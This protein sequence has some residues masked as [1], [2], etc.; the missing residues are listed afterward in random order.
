MNRKI[1]TL[2]ALSLLIII[3]FVSLAWGFNLEK[4]VI[5]KWNFKEAVLFNS[6]ID[7]MTTKNQK[8]ATLEFFPDKTYLLEEPHG[9]NS[10]SWVLLDDGRIKMTSKYGVIEFG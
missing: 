3:A 9:Q 8:G 4:D 2:C 5:G 6:K 7:S 10:G 1:F